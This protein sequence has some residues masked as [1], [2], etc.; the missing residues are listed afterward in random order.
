M[1]KEQNTCLLKGVEG[2]I[3][4]LEFSNGKEASKSVSYT[5]SVSFNGNFE[6]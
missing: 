5:K 1:I 3:W 6:E 4:L 2:R